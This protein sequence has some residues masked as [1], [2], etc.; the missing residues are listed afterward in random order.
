MIGKER[1]Y[2]FAYNI[3]SSNL[4]YKRAEDKKIQVVV[5][6]LLPDGQT[7]EIEIG[8]PG[9]DKVEIKSPTSD[10]ERMKRRGETELLRRTYDGY[11]GTIKT[12]LVPGCQAGDT[13]FIQDDD[14]QEKNGT[15]FVRSVKTTLSAA[16]G[17]RKITLGFRLS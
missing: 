12:W 1:H 16:G 11:D 3:E 6:A 14:Y 5:K 10:L 9:A 15:Y 2:D 13:A 17:V 7:R 8:T 4:S